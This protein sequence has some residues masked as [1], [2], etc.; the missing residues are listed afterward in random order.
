MEKKYSIDVKGIHC[1]G[2]V[3]LI[4]LVLSDTDV[5]FKAVTVNESIGEVTFSTD[6][7]VNEITSLLDNAFQIDLKNYSYTNLHI[8]N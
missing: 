4:K 3:S 5:D 2:C 6:K 8:I 7:D 1:S